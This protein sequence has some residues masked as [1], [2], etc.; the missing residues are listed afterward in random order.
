MKADDLHIDQEVFAYSSTVVVEPRTGK[1]MI[2]TVVV[3]ERREI[4]CSIVNYTL[5][6][7]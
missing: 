6:R 2:N 5:L 4:C 7:L 1:I 3:F